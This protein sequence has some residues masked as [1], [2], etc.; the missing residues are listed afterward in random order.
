MLNAITFLNI[1]ELLKLLQINK[2]YLK[3]PMFFRSYTL[4]S[5]LLAI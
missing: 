3:L 1:K 5:H 4:I 2:N